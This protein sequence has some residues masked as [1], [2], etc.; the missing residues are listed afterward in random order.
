MSES[1][2]LSPYMPFTTEGRLTL[3]VCREERAAREGEVPGGHWGGVK[4]GIKGG[5]NGAG[6]YMSNTPF[7]S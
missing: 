1:V 7:H 6:G 4:L 5:M 3:T 2:Y